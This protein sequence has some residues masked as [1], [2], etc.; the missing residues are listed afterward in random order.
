MKS[1]LISLIAEIGL[2]LLFQTYDCTLYSIGWVLEKLI[3]VKLFLN[4]LADMLHKSK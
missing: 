2:L 3:T 1:C 4:Y